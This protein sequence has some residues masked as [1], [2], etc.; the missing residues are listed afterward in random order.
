MLVKKPRDI[1][2][3]DWALQLISRAPPKIPPTSLPSLLL[4]PS[5]FPPYLSLSFCGHLLSIPSSS[6]KSNTLD[7]VIDVG[8]SRWVRR[9]LFQSRATGQRGC[10][11]RHHHGRRRRRRP[12]RRSRCCRHHDDDGWGGGDGNRLH[13]H[14]NCVFMVID[15]LVNETALVNQVASTPCN[16]FFDMSLF[17]GDV[18][19]VV[20]GWGSTRGWRTG[21]ARR[22]T[23]CFARRIRLE[24]CHLA[25][26]DCV[27]TSV[28]CR[29]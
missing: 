15:T 9:S 27:N 26:V 22:G 6:S 21:A 1:G 19:R 14:L 5:L 23:P 12:R 3:A 25:G 24:T 7:D 4:L 10:L 16:I 11:G 20:R 2:R 17:T 18:R 28:I 8:I 29:L 13:C